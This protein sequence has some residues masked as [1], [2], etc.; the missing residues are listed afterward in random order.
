[1]RGKGKPF[2]N[3]ITATSI[4]YGRRQKFEV[5]DLKLAAFVD[6]NDFEIEVRVKVGA[7]FQ[8]AYAGSSLLATFSSLS[9]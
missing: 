8:F 9:S 5:T 7:L 1:M 2:L 4:P 6:G 3:A